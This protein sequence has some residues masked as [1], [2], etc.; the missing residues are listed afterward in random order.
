LLP[1]DRPAEAEDLPPTLPPTRP[2]AADQ[3]RDSPAT[4]LTPRPGR[5]VWAD[6]A[7]GVLILLVVLWHVTMKHY[8]Q[9]DWNISAPLPV[10]WGLLGEAYIPFMMP[11]FFALSGIFAANALRR[12]WREVL[13]S[14]VAKFLYLFVLWLLVHTVVLAK[15]NPDFKTD[16]ARDAMELLEELTITPPNVWYLYALVL[17]FVIAKV[18]RPL[19]PVLVLGAAFVVSA[20]GSADLVA[21]PGNRE[22][23]YQNLVF[24]LAGAYFRPGMER[25][26]GRAGPRPLLLACAA[27][28]G[29]LL[30]MTL[31]RAEDW[32]GVW[33]LVSA[34][35]V[36]SGIVV[37]AQLARWDVVSRPLAAIGRN[38]L[39]IYVMHM[40]L[41][42]LVD[43]LL[44]EHLSA[45]GPGAQLGVAV[46][47]PI[48]LTA[49]LTLACI[50][51]YRVFQA[52]GVDG[53]LFD[54]PGR[55]RG[56]VGGSVGGRAADS[57][58]RP[59]GP[60]SGEAEPYL[61]QPGRLRQEGR[62]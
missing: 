13:R 52:A 36:G 3:P 47:D 54:L 42:A 18:A 12:P 8:L 31:A 40:P 4:G 46:L 50:A 56:S 39:P 11:L 58:P 51:G 53:W 32:F 1:P 55:R 19:P 28:L 15:V 23:L 17:Y 35:G 33:P 49:F 14:R 59:V 29:V 57:S 24:F 34:V 27:Y 25:L 45:A 26:A 7:K 41:L 38:T 22:G 43:A 62:A 9:I 60:V 44:V 48:L 20:V 16:R 10:A 21:T 30:G 6:V 37:A 2:A 5:T 61:G